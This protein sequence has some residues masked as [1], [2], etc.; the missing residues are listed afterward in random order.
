MP[1]SKE[2][3]QYPDQYL[4]FTEK[5]GLGTTIEITAPT[6]KKAL[7]IRNQYYAFVGALKRKKYWLEAQPLKESHDQRL[8]DAA[9]L[10]YKVVCQVE[11]HEDGTATVR[12]FNRENSWQAKL[13]ATATIEGQTLPEV[14]LE[15]PASLA[16]LA[17]KS[18]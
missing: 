13:L 15:M 18:K 1:R 11:N 3:E 16:A 12:W 9:H 6:A 2:I 14:V 17:E 8:I 7:S 5:A 4:E 10:A